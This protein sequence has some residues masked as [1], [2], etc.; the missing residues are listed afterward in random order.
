MFMLT[1]LLKKNCKKMSRKLFKL[2]NNLLRKLL[3]SQLFQQFHKLSPKLSPKLFHRQLQKL[4]YN[5]SPRQLS[6]PKCRTMCLTPK[7]HHV[8]FLMSKWKHQ[9]LPHKFNLMSTWRDNSRVGEN[10]LPM[11][12]KKNLWRKFLLILL[13][14]RIQKLRLS[15]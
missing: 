12:S 6:N 15:Q 14:N 4:S 10:Y 7:H 8:Q 13:L 5:L 1:T 11:L 3:L 9:F 2:F